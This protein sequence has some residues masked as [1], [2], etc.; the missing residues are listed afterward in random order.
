MNSKY[1]YANWIYSIH[2]GCGDFHTNMN[3]TEGLLQILQVRMALGINFVK[4]F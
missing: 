1:P 4:I 2:V 3:F